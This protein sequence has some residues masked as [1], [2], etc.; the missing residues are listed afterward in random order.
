MENPS[1]LLKAARDHAS[2]LI[3]AHVSPDA[4]FHTLQHTQDVV[5]ASEKIAAQEVLPEEDT[6]ALYVAAW[7]HDTGYS[8]GKSRDHELISV[9]HALDFFETHP[10]ADEFK[11]KVKGCILATRMPQTRRINWKKSCAMRICFIWDHPISRKKAGCSAM[12]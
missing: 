6:L 3:S 2:Q 12:S 10:V 1:E 7:F 4:T 5:A 11:E 8:A 9:Q